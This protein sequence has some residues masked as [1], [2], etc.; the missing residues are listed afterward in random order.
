MIIIILSLLRSLI[1]I[2]VMISPSTS[3]A[4]LRPSGLAPARAPAGCCNSNSNNTS[5]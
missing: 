1:H 3:P 2:V 5:N 4:L